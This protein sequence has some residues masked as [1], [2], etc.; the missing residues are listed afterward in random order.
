MVVVHQL[1]KRTQTVVSLPP[2]LVEKDTYGRE[3][4][5][6]KNSDGNACRYQLYFCTKYLEK[7]DDDDLVTQ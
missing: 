6:K 3:K 7:T 4:H 2:F 5:P 1:Q